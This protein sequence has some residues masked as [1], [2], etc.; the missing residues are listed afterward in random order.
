M[1]LAHSKL[2]PACSHFH[3]D[4]T[5]S[6]ALAY[7]RVFVYYEDRFIWCVG[8]LV[9]VYRLVR[10]LTVGIFSSFRPTNSFFNANFFC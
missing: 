9:F 4:L 6:N 10:G 2:T 1:V 3:I 8:L 5:V 7:L